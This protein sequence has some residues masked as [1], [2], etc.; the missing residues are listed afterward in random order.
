M[1][2]VPVQQVIIADKSIVYGQILL[3]ENASLPS[4]PYIPGVPTY[5]WRIKQLPRHFPKFHL[6]QMCPK[7]NHAAPRKRN[8]PHQQAS[9]KYRK[10]EYRPVASVKFC[11]RCPRQFLRLK[12]VL[13]PHIVDIQKFQIV[14]PSPPLAA[15]HKSRLRNRKSMDLTLLT[16]KPDFP[17]SS[18]ESRYQ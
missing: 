7:T 6:V 1:R 4:L 12:N 13:A 3:S 5:P 16:L 11:F 15:G 8:A 2:S 17:H 18:V 10:S 14:M 9:E